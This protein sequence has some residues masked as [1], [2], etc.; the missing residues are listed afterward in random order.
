MSEDILFQI[1]DRLGITRGYLG[2]DGQERP[3]SAD[4]AHA[5]VRGMGHQV[6]EEALKTLEQESWA[7]GVHGVVV[8]RPGEAVRVRWTVP[9]HRVRDVHR[10][11]LTNDETGECASQGECVPDT[12][13]IE[14]QGEFDDRR[15]LVLGALEPG[16]YRLQV[17]DSHCHV[18]CA[19]IEAHRPKELDARRM[20]G[21]AI[22]LYA[23]RTE[24][25]WGIGDF[26]DL[27]SVVHYFASLGADFVGLNP[28]HSLFPDNPSQ[29]SPYGPS[30]RSW[31][32]P[33]YIAVE[34]VP[35]VKSSSVVQSKIQDQG[36]RERLQHLR[37][38]E[39]VDYTGVNA[40]KIEILRLAY[41][42]WSKSGERFRAFEAFCDRP[43][44]M[45]HATWE[46]L[47]VHFASQ[48]R[49]GFFN[50]PEEYRSPGNEAVSRFVDERSEDVRFR[51][52]LQWIASVQ[53]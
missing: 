38:T 35:E 46:V 33:I 20:W 23:L 32:N 29:A 39:F 24:N 52:Y 7:A 50:W 14:E 4:I 26:D 27:E 34:E 36:F 30:S 22:Q 43:G 31:L 48:G 44:L 6:S 2:L 15:T 10:W 47:Q 12:C 13:P 25:N 3:T 28:L 51:A 45:Q 53:L 5:F 8:A 1:A 42:E 41:D 40:I 49:H 16:Y 17:E 9:H 21:P 19:P 18:V 37:D 11:T